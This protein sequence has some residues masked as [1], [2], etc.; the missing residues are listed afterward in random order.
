MNVFVLKNILI[1]TLGYCMFYIYTNSYFDSKITSIEYIQKKK[2]RIMSCL[3]SLLLTLLGVI[4]VFFHIKNIYYHLF[5]IYIFSGYLLA[6]LLIG[7]F[8]YRK[9]VNLLTGY[10][11]HTLYLLLNVYIL[12]L[13]NYNKCLYVYSLYMIEELPT[14]ILNIGYIFPKYRSDILFGITMIL[15]RIIY[16][17][18]L[19]IYI[20]HLSILFKTISI[21]ALFLHK[22]WVY[23]WLY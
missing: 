11:H 5:V 16:H 21:L 1:Y 15:F 4:H 22:Y 19:L 17:I 13:E 2:S 12:H 14:A 8:C 7:F 18:Y 10:I 6:D 3:S 20:N 23:N 9:Q